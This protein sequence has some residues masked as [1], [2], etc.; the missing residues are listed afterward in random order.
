[1]KHGIAVGNN[2]NLV[3]IKENEPHVISSCMGAKNNPYVGKD[4]SAKIIG[5]MLDGAMVYKHAQ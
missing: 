3:F 5:L 1:M 4:S 2:A